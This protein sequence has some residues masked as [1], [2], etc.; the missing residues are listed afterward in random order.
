MT[1]IARLELGFSISCN[2]AKYSHYSD[3]EF[4]NTIGPTADI[5]GQ[6]VGIAVND[7]SGRQG[8]QGKNESFV[9]RYYVLDQPAIELG[10]QH[11]A[12]TT[13]SIACAQATLVRGDS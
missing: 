10:R 7:P 1:S 13:L 5:L 12:A 3:L 8:R 6:Q 2:S 4:F 11:H 9:Q